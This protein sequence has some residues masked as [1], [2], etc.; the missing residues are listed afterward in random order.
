MRLILHTAACWLV[1]TIR[2]PIAA[3]EALATGEFSTIRLRL[4][5]VAVRVRETPSRIRLAFAANRP[6]G[7]LFRD[8]VKVCVPR[9]T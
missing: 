6:Y 8:L 7:A 4:P 1:R 3:S 5:K 2:D 9:P